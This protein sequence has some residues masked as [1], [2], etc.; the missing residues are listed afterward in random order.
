MKMVSLEEYTREVAGDEDRDDSIYARTNLDY[1]PFTDMC[2]RDGKECRECECHLY[3]EGECLNFEVKR[4]FY[5]VAGS[6]DRSIDFDI[7]DRV[8]VWWISVSYYYGDKFGI[9]LRTQN[10]SV[11]DLALEELGLNSYFVDRTRVFPERWDSLPAVNAFLRFLVRQADEISAKLWE[12][13][14]C[15]KCG[16]FA[17]YSVKLF[18]AG[19]IRGCNTYGSLCGECR[20]QIAVAWLRAQ[21]REG[22]K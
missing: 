9:G 16:E 8:S 1:Y 11:M 2:P 10:N 21:R 3:L 6:A 4:V 18:R 5:E 12:H 14:T 15:A 13:Y 20:E 19:W 17:P 22:T 7:G